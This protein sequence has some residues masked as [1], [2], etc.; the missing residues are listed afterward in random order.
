MRM[1]E[2]PARPCLTRLLT[3][4]WIYS[5]ILKSSTS[6]SANS[7]LPAYH[8][9]FQSSMMPVR[10]PVGLTFWPMNHSLPNKNPPSASPPWGTAGQTLLSALLGCDRR[11]FH[12]GQSNNNMRI[13]PL[14]RKR[15]P[16]GA[17][18]KSLHGRR[19][20][21]ARFDHDQLILVAGAAI[22]GVAHRAFE[23]FFEKPSALVRI[24]TQE[25]QRLVRHSAA[26]QIR[27]LPNLAGVHVRESGLCLVVHRQPHPHQS[28]SGG[29]I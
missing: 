12:I 24:E 4:F 26:D 20:I 9:L 6:R 25:L 13:A 10:K 14:D 27:E 2:I 17:R 22:L 1:L 11:F 7:C 8:V 15:R 29:R 18:L 28:N 5:R 16:A 23:H 21:N 19:T 3:Y